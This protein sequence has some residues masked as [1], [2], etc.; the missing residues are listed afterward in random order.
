[1]NDRATLATRLDRLRGASVLCI[2][3]AMLDRYVY[4]DASR[5]SPEA[6][7]P[8]LRVDR[9][10]T[11]LGGAGNVARNVAA[12]GGNAHFIS[13]IGTDGIGE[14]FARLASQISGIRPALVTDG[15]RPTPLKTRYIAGTQ[16][17]LRADQEM[18]LPVS[19]RVEDQIV[20][21]ALTAIRTCQAVVLSDYGKGVLSAR[22]LEQ[23]IA[24]AKKAGI[25]TL[26]DPKGRDYARYRGAD[27]VTPNR[28]ELSEATG[29]P[30]AN[31]D[32]VTSA[33][34]RIVNVCGIGSVLATRGPDGMTL[35]SGARDPEHFRAESRE[36]FDV[37]GAGDTVIAALA[38]ALAAGLRQREAV[39]VA[40]V[41]AGI[42]VA[43]V[44]TAVAHIDEINAAL[45]HGDE[46][47]DEDAKLVT[48]ER[49]A[50]MAERWRSEGLKVGLTNG[51][52]DLLHPG[53]VS[54]LKAAR[55]ACDR[56]IVAINADASVTRL[57]GAGR[58]VQS[59]S[60]RAAVLS[61]LSCVDLV[62]VF[63]QD[64]P[65]ELI[66]RLRPDLLAKGSE[67]TADQVVGGDIVEGYGG[68][69]MLVDQV[70]GFSTTETIA[71][72]S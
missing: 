67:Y 21:A 8:V 69:I 47:P 14:E 44:G 60:A 26:V 45:N 35:V 36:V 6:P 23:V 57:K 7:V 72:L 53:H 41:A 38:L 2:G 54:L 11:M 27:M 66:E 1:M 31:D 49:A 28:K 56:L 43:K 55:D 52:F 22:V 37:S 34:R 64:T 25:P 13:L 42:V 71:R 16:Q 32:Q 51:C 46:T 18:A 50:E 15:S 3:D 4:G 9:E 29:L 5:I 24:G 70:P 20:E 65:V 61:A 17:L 40:N 33:A 48:W 59:E 58:P 68:R 12:M 10:A 19:G 63:G 62:V 30:T 39:P